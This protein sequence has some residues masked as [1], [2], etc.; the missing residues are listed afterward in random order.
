[1]GANVSPVIASLVLNYVLDEALKKLP[2]RIRLCL[3]YVDDILAIIPK[4]LLD[5]TIHALNSIHPKIQFI[6][7]LEHKEKLPYL[8][9]CLI[10]QPNEQIAHNWYVKE[11]ASGRILNF[12]SNYPRHQI[13]NTASNLIK[14]VFS[15]SSI[16]FHN[17][18]IENAKTIL[19]NNGFPSKIITQLIHK[20]QQQTEHIPSKCDTHTSVHYTSLPFH[21]NITHN[22]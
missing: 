8:D 22:A 20:H 17:E 12:R 13:V 7:E 19:L 9:L 18:N 3:K 6:H 16:Q 5:I 4:H 11:T 2:Y 1:M 15:L 14:R 21:K 10:R